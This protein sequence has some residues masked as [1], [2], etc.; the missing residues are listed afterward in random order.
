MSDVR[1]FPLIID[2]ADTDAEGGA[3][4]DVPSPHTGDLIARIAAATPA[5]VD[6]AVDAARR[7]LPGWRSTP[8]LERGAAIARFARL[9]DDEAEELA[10]LVHEEMGKPLAEAQAEVARAAEVN[11]HYA[12]EAERLWETSFRVAARSGWATTCGASR[13]AWW[14]PSRPGTSRWR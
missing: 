9:F 8:P 3:T 11:H 12:A 13:S 7:A 2:G 4:L 6:R 5:D 10:R 14:R 1:T